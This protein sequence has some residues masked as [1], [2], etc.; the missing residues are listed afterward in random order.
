MQQ[1]NDVGTQYRSS[2]Y[3]INKQQKELALDASK[4]FGK[5]LP[6]RMSVKTEIK[7]LKAFYYAEEKHQQYLHKNPNGYCGLKGTGFKLELDD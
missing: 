3:W 6:A 2:I 4:K 5:Q 1:G 7:E